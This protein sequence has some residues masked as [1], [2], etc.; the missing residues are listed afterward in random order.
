ML[1]LRLSNPRRALLSITTLL[2][3]CLG[4]IYAYSVVLAPQKELWGWSVSQM[5]LVF[6][7]SITV[8]TL[9][10]LLGARLNS[11]LGSRNSLLIAGVL[12]A[13]GFW[14]CSVADGASAFFTTCLCYCVIGGA[15]IG[16]AYDVLLPA[17]TRWFPDHTGIA[18][19]IGLMGFGMGGF[20]MGPALAACYSI[21]SWRLVLQILG[22]AF[23][24]L[25]IFSA[26]FVAEKRSPSFRLSE[27]ACDAQPSEPQA[28]GTREAAAQ[29]RPLTALLAD[30]R[31]KLLYLWLFTICGAGMGISGLGRELPLSLGADAMAAAVIIGF[32]SVGSG[33][34]RFAGGFFADKFGAPVTIRAT[35]MGMVTAQGLMLLSM[36][37]QSLLIQT[38]ALLGCGFCWGV[39]VIMMTYVCSETWGAQAMS[40]NLAV[41]NTNSI[42]SS[43]VGSCGGG[44]LAQA[45]GVQ[46][47][48]GALLGFA[49]VATALSGVLGRAVASAKSAAQAVASLPDQPQAA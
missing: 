43:L 39:A 48:L 23:L 6:A 13:A 19:G 18:Q 15:G 20:V 27:G 12:V 31:F 1:A 14:G 2:L 42:F 28:A 10:G 17:I 24:G 37:F 9:G 25:L 3:F 33:L 49:I 7:L 30:R 45:F 21:A 32:V 4:L 22:I 26:F 29:K 5:T 34:G 40:R 47:A 16:I 36:V 8:F 44:L 35:S 38:V 41:V 46:A 11:A